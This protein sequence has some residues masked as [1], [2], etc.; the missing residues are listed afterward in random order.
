[1]SDHLGPRDM[2]GYLLAGDEDPAPTQSDPWWLLQQAL[3][4]DEPSARALVQWLTPIALRAAMRV[5]GRR[6]DAEDA[7]QE[8][9]LSLWRRP[10]SPGHGARLSTYLVTVVLNNC[11]SMLRGRRLLD[12][13]D[14][15]R[16]EEAV[17]DP[18]TNSLVAS[19]AMTPQG[20]Q[21]RLGLALMRLSPRQR[22][23]LAMWAYADAT[24]AD[25]ARALLIDE[26]AAHQLMHRARSA[27]R[28]HV[29]GDQHEQ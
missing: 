4:G 27:L 9:F 29:T 13:I 22:L 15:Q 23:A 11:R 12:P 6:E 14:E 8:A 10:P 1:M 2:R 19:V 7:V 20:A 16:G 24:S 17:A 25:V 5:M 26:N 28:K 21:Q 3:T 18:I